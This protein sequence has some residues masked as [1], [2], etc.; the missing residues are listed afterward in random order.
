ML[1]DRSRLPEG[2]QMFL[3]GVLVE[4]IRLALLDM[5]GVSGAL[6]ETGSKTVAEV[7]RRQYRLAVDHPDGAFGA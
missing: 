7:I 3:H 5:N 2:G 1:V 6:T 4:F